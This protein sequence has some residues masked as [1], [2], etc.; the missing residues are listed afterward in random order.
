MAGLGIFG[1]SPVLRTAGYHVRL[2][3]APA[4]AACGFGSAAEA[5]GGPLES[6][7]ADG[8]LI[9]LFHFALFGEQN[10]WSRLGFVLR[11][12]RE[13]RKKQG[14]EKM[15]ASQPSHQASGCETYK[16]CTSFSV[17]CALLKT[18]GEPTGSLRAAGS[19]GAA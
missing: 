18:Q 1:Q 16:H 9:T 10:F 12:N 11:M 4:R 17:K 2:C 5:E 13:R 15:G 14:S 8:R 7:S 19:V 3:R 6:P